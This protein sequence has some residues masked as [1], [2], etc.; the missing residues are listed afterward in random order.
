MIVTRNC[1]SLE[2]TAHG[3]KVTF[4]I[5][6]DLRTDKLYKKCAFSSITI[7]LILPIIIFSESGLSSGF[8]PKGAMNS[9]VVRKAN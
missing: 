6:R 8:L 5:T 1:C 7:T 9:K 4:R 3:L 2:A